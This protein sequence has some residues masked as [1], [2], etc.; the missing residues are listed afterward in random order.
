[1]NWS[2]Y[3]RAVELSHMRQLMRYG[4]EDFERD[5]DACIAIAQ[6]VAV[7]GEKEH[8]SRLTERSFT[9]MEAYLANNPDARPWKGIHV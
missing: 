3:Y 9:R 7:E 5:W 4:Q 8:L 2:E 6:I 1:M